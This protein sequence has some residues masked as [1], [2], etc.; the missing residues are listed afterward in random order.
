MRAL[1]AARRWRP[2]RAAAD[3]ASARPALRLAVLAVIPMLWIVGANLAPLAQMA[4]ISLMERYPVPPG[5]PVA[6]TLS[7][8]AAFWER[9]LYL[10]A[11]I[12]SF[13]FATAVTLITLLVMFPV[14]WYV[15][16]VAPRE[17]R[18]RLLLILVAPF[19][20]SEIVRSIA[21]MLVLANRG[22]LNL[23]LA[24]VG[25]IDDPLPMLYTHGSLAVGV[26]YLTSLY[27]L[28][29]LY[30]A[31]EK[32]DDGLLQASANLGAGPLTRLRRIILPLAR[33]GI[34][35]GCTLVF[36]MA[37]GLYAM[38]QLLGGPDT[39]LFAVTIGQ[40]F[41]RAGDAWPLGSALSILLILG[42]LGWVGAFA[43]LWKSP[44]RSA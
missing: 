30:A 16:K 29:P 33:D 17:A 24:G 19:W 35:G 18:L 28:L 39:T 20:V 2:W 7:H 40:V 32:I 1:V 26:L 42:A 8:Y 44:R 38:P 37:I 21:W 27:M 41:S 31:F 5:E 4:A 13:I 11:Y 6:W 23:A 34:V 12:R 3:A 14:A 25:V 10:N 36:L 15:A 43:L 9:S 22:A